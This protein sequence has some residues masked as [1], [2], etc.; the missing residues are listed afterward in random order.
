MF[1]DKVRLFLR[2][3]RI[4]GF[5]ITCLFVYLFVQFRSSDTGVY[6]IF[7]FYLSIYLSIFIFF[8]YFWLIVY[9]LFRIFYIYNK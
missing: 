8:L 9:C 2:M 5:L 7:S 1:G 6:M 3:G 4:V